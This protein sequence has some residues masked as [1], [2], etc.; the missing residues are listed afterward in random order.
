[1]NGS[2]LAGDFNEPSTPFPSLRVDHKRTKI[3]KGANTVPPH[4]LA[5]SGTTFSHELLKTAITNTEVEPT[6]KAKSTT[7]LP[8]DFPITP[9]AQELLKVAIARA[10]IK[11]NQ[12]TTPMKR[13]SNDKLIEFEVK[14]PVGRPRIHPVK[15]LDPNRV[16]RGTLCTLLD[17]FTLYMFLINIV[18]TQLPRVTSL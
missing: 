14:R 18:R 3:K 1:M 5:T 10:E 7:V 13:K 16:K 12:T 4:F 2:I 15:I 6:N 17:I 9:S 8:A 11:S